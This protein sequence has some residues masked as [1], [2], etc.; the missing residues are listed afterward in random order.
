VI[1]TLAVERSTTASVI[2]NTM[3]LDQI[4]L[5]YRFYLRER[6]RDAQRLGETLGK[7]LIGG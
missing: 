4:Q 6:H 1:E 7:L 2:E 3:T 5:R